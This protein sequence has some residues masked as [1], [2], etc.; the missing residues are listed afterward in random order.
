V[1]LATGS[2][3][4]AGST[5]TPMQTRFILVHRAFYG[6]QKKVLKVGAVAEVPAWL[7][8]EAVQ[9]GRASYAEPPA[10]PPPVNDVSVQPVPEPK[11]TK[12]ARK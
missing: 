9:C 2:L 5:A 11:G 4:V 3:L 1:L 7:A 12:H 8:V 6:H 10:P